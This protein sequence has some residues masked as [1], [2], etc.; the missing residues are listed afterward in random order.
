MIET[1]L[2]H[3]KQNCTTGVNESWFGPPQKIYFG[4]PNKGGPARKSLQ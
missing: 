3:N 4:P 1:L 2:A